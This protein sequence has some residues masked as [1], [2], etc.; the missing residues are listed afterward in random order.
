MLKRN[1]RKIAHNLHIHVLHTIGLLTN[2]AIIFLDHAI[3]EFTARFT[4]LFHRLLVIVWIALFEQRDQDTQRFRGRRIIDRGDQHLINLRQNA[5]IMTAKQRT[6]IVVRDTS[7]EGT[8]IVDELRLIESDQRLEF[9]AKLQQL[10]NLIRLLVAHIFTNRSLG[11]D[12]VRQPRQ[13][14]TQQLTHRRLHNRYILAGM[15]PGLQ[16]FDTVDIAHLDELNLAIGLF[17][18]THI[19][20]CQ[21]RRAIIVRVEKLGIVAFYA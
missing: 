13:Q 11:I 7:E 5:L 3:H 17:K 10:Q 8:K 21:P 4:H 1:L 15:Q 2:G 19:V 6:D 9:T 18:T 12:Q 14:R 20:Q 16:R